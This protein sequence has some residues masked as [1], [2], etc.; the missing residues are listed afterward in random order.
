MSSTHHTTPGGAPS[1]LS[2]NNGTARASEHP[3]ATGE[4]APGPDDPSGGKDEPRATDAPKA[5][6]PATAAPA[7]PAAPAG[8]STPGRPVASA[9]PVLGRPTGHTGTAPA[10]R[11]DPTA[12]RAALGRP[13]TPTRPSTPTQPSAPAQPGTPGRPGTPPA[14]SRPSESSAPSGAHRPAAPAKDRGRAGADTGPASEAAPA[15]ETRPEQARTPW[16]EGDSVLT[17]LVRVRSSPPKEGWRA[18]VYR[19][20]RGRWNL[21]LSEPEARLREQL[22]KIRTPLP[23]PHSVVVGS[24]KGG[25]GKTTVSSLLGL[26][27]AEHRGDRVIAVDANPDAGTLGDRLVGEEPA[28]KT[29]VRDLLDNIG[30]VRSSTQLA[31]YTHLAGRLQVLTSEQEP[32]LSEMFSAGDYESV[33]R[34]LARFFEAI[35]T[36]SGTGVVHSAMQGSLAHADSLVIVGAPTQ[37]GASRASRTLQWLATHGYRELAED[38]VV[39][40]SCDRHSPYVDES[41]V[42]DH[43]RARCRAVIELPADQHLSTGG[44]IDLEALH[45]VTRDAALQLAA[46]VAEGFHTSRARGLSSHG[47]R[48]EALR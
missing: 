6:D 37:D 34:L 24:I 16:D 2:D 48:S 26:A 23:G 32:E 5:A 14:A 44:L 18:I 36:D 40:L 4:Q 29:T 47:F 9:E 17:N 10:T 3:P 30:H 43:F 19:A 42:R 13:G 27:L 25:I 28:S 38:A 15:A 1:W 11:P 46:T 31:G 20:T 12:G 45:P 39:V 35:I 33:L 22:Q 8:A 21:G 7:A 41:V